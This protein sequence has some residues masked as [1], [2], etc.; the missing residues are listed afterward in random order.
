M[1]QIPR[2]SLSI[3]I[4]IQMKSKKIFTKMVV[5]VVTV[6]WKGIDSKSDTS[7]TGAEGL[8]FH[9]SRL[10]YFPHQILA[11]M[12]LNQNRVLHPN[13]QTS[14]SICGARYMRHAIRTWSAVC[15]TA[16]HLQF[17]EGARSHLC[18]DNWNWPTPVRR[19]LSLTQA[20]RG[21]LIPTG[22]VL[23]LGIK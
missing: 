19:R 11:V 20:A 7:S 10:L 6:V 3:Y 18:L 4:Q 5:V 17:G 8:C 15:S 1:I 22:L 14:C 21:K 23:V 16:P 13:R 12:L 2:S 9:Y